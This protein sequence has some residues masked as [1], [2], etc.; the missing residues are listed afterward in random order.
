MGISSAEALQISNPL[1]KVFDQWQSQ[2]SSLNKYITSKVSRQLDNLSASL[3]GDLKG[4]VNK[5]VGVLGL[6]SATEVREKVENIAASSNSAV[7]NVDQATNEIDRQITRA[8]ANTTLSQEGQQ[9]T[10]QQVEQTQTSI[11]QH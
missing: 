4:E 7:N 3:S 5:S 11:E 1:A 8:S 9:L 2:L 6:P 10:K